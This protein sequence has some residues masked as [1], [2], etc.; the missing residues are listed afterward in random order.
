MLQLTDEQ[1]K[2][3]DVLR[4]KGTTRQGQKDTLS[5]VNRIRR[6]CQTNTHQPVGDYQTYFTCN[7]CRTADDG[8]VERAKCACQKFCHDWLRMSA[9]H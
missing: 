7:D 3:L 1:K 6:Y 9:C 2:W 5:P 8:D 4:L